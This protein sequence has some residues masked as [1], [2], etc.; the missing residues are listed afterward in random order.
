MIIFEPLL[1]Q[2]GILKFAFGIEVEMRVSMYHH[3]A[4]ILGCATKKSME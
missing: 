4:L 2:S 1:L 3:A